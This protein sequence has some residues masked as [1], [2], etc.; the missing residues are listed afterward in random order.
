MLPRVRLPDDGV[1]MHGAVDFVRC[2]CHA[3]SC[4]PTVGARASQLLWEAATC[5]FP[6]LSAGMRSHPS[7]ASGSP[8]PSLVAGSWSDGWAE[9][10]EM[11]QMGGRV[12]WVLQLGR[13][14][15]AGQ[16]PLPSMALG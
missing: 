15:C 12:K 6:K 4:F 7:M 10:K 13:E 8:V 5:S 2:G 11:K 14:A 16:S 9:E 3:T 1:I